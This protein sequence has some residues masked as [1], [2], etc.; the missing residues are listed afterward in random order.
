MYKTWRV[1][2]LWELV[3]TIVGHG[4]NTNDGDLFFIFH[5]LMYRVEEKS[6]VLR[7]KHHDTYTLMIKTL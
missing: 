5:T 6:S 4:D 1:D 7:Q 3:V 2:Q